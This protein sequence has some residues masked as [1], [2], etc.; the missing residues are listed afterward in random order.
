MTKYTQTDAV[1]DA[2]EILGDLT[3]L[4][5]LRLE[6][7]KFYN[8]FIHQTV[9]SRVRKEW[10]E[11]NKLQRDCR[12]YSAQPRRNMFKDDYVSLEN[13]VVAQ[14]LLNNVINSPDEFL[15]LIT[16][17]HSLEHMANCLKAATKKKRKK[18]VA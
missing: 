5:V 6:S 12:T 2:L 17:F 1:L 11:A 16:S 14:S 3:S 4:E 8:G 7:M 18:K 13:Q 15:S 9:I 10:R